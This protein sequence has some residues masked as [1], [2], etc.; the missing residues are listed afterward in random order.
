MLN[1]LI[2]RFPDISEETISKYF[3][4]FE[5][6]YTCYYG[7]E[8][9]KNSCD[10]EIILHLIAHLIVNSDN[11]KNGDTSKS[12]SSESAR[13]VSASYVQQQNITAMD[14]FFST[15]PYGQVYLMLIRNNG[16]GSIFV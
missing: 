2:A 8:Y 9:G 3:S 7:V 13:N 6:T 15:T 10:D 12:V 16:V 5:K 4:L 14:A 1:D 11:T